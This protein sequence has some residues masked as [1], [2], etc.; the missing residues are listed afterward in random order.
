M[1]G[2][3][4]VSGDVEG[5][6][7]PLSGMMRSGRKKKEQRQ[8]GFPT[9]IPLTSCRN[10][11]CRAKGHRAGSSSPWGWSVVSPLSTLLANEGGVS[12]GDQAVGP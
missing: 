2:Q 10:S 1:V 9:S 5:L 4:G 6:G 11:T 3:V 12:S 7:G 8:R